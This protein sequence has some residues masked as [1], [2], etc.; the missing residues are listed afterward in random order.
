MA[1]IV[2]AFD[3]VIHRPIAVPQGAPA[4]VADTIATAA[5]AALEQAAAVASKANAAALVLCGRILD[6]SRSSPA[7]AARL[8]Q[9]IA[10][11]AARGCRT[12]MIA[13]E[14]SFCHDISR[15]LGEPRGLFFVTPLAPLEFE[16]RGLAVEIAS[17]HGPSSAG[18]GAAFTAAA[19]PLHRRIVI[20]W[21]NALWNP[22]PCL[23]RH[24]GAGDSARGRRL[25]DGGG[26]VDGVVAARHL[27]DLGV[28]TPAGAAAGCALH[29]GTPGPIDR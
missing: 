27:L 22:E 26:R 2:F 19:S 20:G 12:V 8:R 3:P 18:S 5:V 7:Q 25:R 29:A 21:D 15:M 10:S 16:V 13:D 28:A 4:A 24:S 9:V 6:P 23:R 11:L 1:D 14:T 17:A